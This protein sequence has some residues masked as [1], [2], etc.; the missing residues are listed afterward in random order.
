MLE[1]FQKSKKQFIKA[2]IILFLIL[3]SLILLYTFY[4]SEINFQG[5]K[6]EKYIK[7]YILSLFLILFFLISL[8]FNE[9]FQEYLVIITFSTIFSLYTFEFY[10]FLKFDYRV[11]TVKYKKIVK[12]SKIKIY[13]DFEKMNIPSIPYYRV[14]NEFLN[15]NQ[16]IFPVSGVSN[17]KTIYCNENNKQINYMSDRYGFRNEDKEWDNKKVDVILIGDSFAQGACVDSKNTLSSNMKKISNLN[18]INLGMSGHGPL[19]ELIVLREYAYFIKPKKIF[20]FFYEG[21][22]LTKDL[23]AELSSDFLKKY[24]HPDFKQDLIKKQKIIDNLLLKDLKKKMLVENLTN[25]NITKFNNNHVSKFK[26]FLENTKY[27]RLWAVRNVLKK[28]ISEKKINPEF[29][30]ILKLAKKEVSSWG[31]KLYFV[32]LPEKTRYQNTFYREVYSD[33]FR[34]KR[35]ILDIAHNLNLQV[36]DVDD[37]I[38]Y[39]IKNPTDLYYLHFNEDG[40]KIISNHLSKFIKNEY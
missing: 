15:D 20:W 35:K 24:F 18:I 8:R 12:E 37:D 4:I 9:K 34:N 32:Y 3:S 40:Y 30:N 36:I 16:N 10:Y 19:K 2:S 26:D 5:S 17:I 11:T 33:Q 1:I 21:N 29:E 6:H 31:G 38:F 14:E 27:L 39:D 22:D 25:D 13:E 7:Y 23:E 28:N